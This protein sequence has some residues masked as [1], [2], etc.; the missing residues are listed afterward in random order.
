MSNSNNQSQQPIGSKQRN[1]TPDRIGIDVL[2]TFVQQIEPVAFSE[3]EGERV[4]RD[5]YLIGSIDHLLETARKYRWDV[6]IKNEVP[7]FYTSEFWQRIA[8][9]PFMHLL[10]AVGMKQGIPYAIVKHHRFVKELVKQFASEAWFPI[11]TTS[12]VPK[13][14]LRNG[15]LHFTPNG[16]ERKPFDKQDGLTYQLDY[17][18]APDAPAPRFKAFIEHVLPD[19]AVRKLLFQYIGYVFLR[20]MNLE[21][22][23]FLFGSGANGKS[24]FLNVIKALIGKEQC[25][26]YSLED[27]TKKDYHRA[28]LGNYILNV[29][30]EISSRLKTSVFKQMVSREPLQARSPYGKPFIIHEYATSIFATNELPKDVEQTNA[31]F[32]RFLIIPFDVRIPDDEQDPDLAKKIIDS[33]MSGVLNYV[34]Q[35]ARSLLREK[36]FAIPQAVLE[37]VEKFRRES[38]CVATFLDAKRYHPSVEK[39]KPLQAMYDVYKEHCLAEGIR[40]IPKRTFAQRLRNLGYSVVPFGGKKILV[41]YVEQA[42]DAG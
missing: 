8:P 35:G 19:G 2:D 32:R 7:Y 41:V 14:N 29:C 22:V 11:L 12:G 27:L 31:F 23:L 20:D 17:D 4:G 34:V 16:V 36:K 24:V 39:C 28:E 5:D 38:N 3:V 26:A 21:R 9:P 10:K 33:E 40:A 42:D 1:V 15:T 30:T 13:I 18:Y 37:T 25:C 6:G